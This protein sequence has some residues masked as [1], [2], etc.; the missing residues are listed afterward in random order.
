MNQL[1]ANKTNEISEKDWIQCIFIPFKWYIVIFLDV[2]SILIFSTVT[3]VIFK[4]RFLGSG[5]MLF[6]TKFL[7]NSA[8][9]RPPVITNQ[10]NSDCCSF[11][12][13][14]LI[15]ITRLPFS[16]ILVTKLIRWAFMLVHHDE[17]WNFIYAKYRLH[18]TVF[19]IEFNFRA[20]GQFDHTKP[21]S[22]IQSIPQQK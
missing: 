16:G 13:L 5:K 2:S 3:T 8:I 11:L 18:H 20:F 12:D 19:P 6:G 1:S 14:R 9:A 21:I 17:R 10:P 7:R 4:T 15:P 22:I